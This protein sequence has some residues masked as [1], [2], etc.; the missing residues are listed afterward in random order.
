MCGPPLT[1]APPPPIPPSLP[2]SRMYYQLKEIVQ[3]S[4]RV[5]TVAPLAHGGAGSGV[6]GSS[7]SPEKSGAARAAALALVPVSP[8]GP[9][10]LAAT[11]ERQAGREA[12]VRTGGGRRRWAGRRRE[13]V[14]RDCP[15]RCWA[16][17]EQQGLGRSLVGWAQV[18][19]A[20]PAPEGARLRHP[21]QWLPRAAPPPRR[22]AACWM[23]WRSSRRGA[24]ATW[25]RWRRTCRAPTRASPARRSSCSRCGLACMRGGAVRA[26][27]ACLVGGRGQL[28]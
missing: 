6:A 13:V 28:L 20:W 22:W 1:H 19:D 10:G 24:R 16:L 9:P 15:M 27:R 5:P 4:A 23:C 18:D 21:G 14:G 3:A 7:P 11:G 26:L 17:G 2:A 12:K 8:S 25:P